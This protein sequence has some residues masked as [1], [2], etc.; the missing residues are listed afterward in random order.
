MKQE[1]SQLQKRVESFL[2]RLFMATLVFATAFVAENV[3]ALELSPTVTG[4]LALMAG[5]LS[6]YLNSKGV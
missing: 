6:K 3:S 2:W 1:K 4:I 5:E